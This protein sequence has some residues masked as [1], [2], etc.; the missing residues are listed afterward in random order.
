MPTTA[1]ASYREFIAQMRLPGQLA[2]VD[3]IVASFCGGAVGVLTT[4]IIVEANN[5]STQERRRCFYCLV[6]ASRLFVC[7]LSAFRLRH[8][9]ETDLH[10][11][12]AV[13]GQA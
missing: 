9:A 7:W 6:S 4:L 5:A 3:P 1:G 2:A 12:C 11:P 8:L 10:T 13:L